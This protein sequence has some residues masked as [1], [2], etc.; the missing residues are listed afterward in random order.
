MERVVD[1]HRGT[2][3]ASEEGVTVRTVEHL[4]AALVGSGVWNCRVDLGAEEVPILDGSSLPWVEAIE[5]AGLSDQARVMPALRIDR[6]LEFTSEG[7]ALYRAAPGGSL[8]IAVAIEF[9]RLPAVDPQRAEVVGLPESFAAEI[10]PA[11]T[12]CHSSELGYLIERGLVQGG[13]LQNALVIYDGVDP[14]SDVCQRLDLPP[15]DDAGPEPGSPVSGLAF[16]LSEEPARHKLLDVIGDL[17]LLGRPIL[18]QIEAIRP[19]HAGNVEFARH[20]RSVLSVQF[21]TLT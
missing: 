4:L 14:W 20:L 6:V 19:G 10:A 3:L 5:E 11:R 18:G 13:S 7:G 8:A 2:T 12:F 16:R 9:P 21:E 17:A 15:T 1:T